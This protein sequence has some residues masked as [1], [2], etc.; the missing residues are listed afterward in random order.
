VSKVKARIVRAQGVKINNI[1]AKFVEWN[2]W[3]I[4]I[5]YHMQKEA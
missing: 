2:I 5:S 4:I 3:L 1:L